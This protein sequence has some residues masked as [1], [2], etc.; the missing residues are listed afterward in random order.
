MT[1]EV[2]EKKDNCHLSLFLEGPRKS[3]K[4]LRI[5]DKGNYYKTFQSSQ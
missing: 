4:L 5:A 2:Y 3:S 1:A